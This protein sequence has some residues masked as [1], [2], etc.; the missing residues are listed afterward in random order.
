MIKKFKSKLI[1][2]F[3]SLVVIVVAIYVVGLFKNG[4]YET[5]TVSKSDLVITTNVSGKVVPGQEINLSFETPGKVSVINA[6][7]GDEVKEGDILARLNSAQ[8]DSEIE[9]ALANLESQEA[10]LQEISGNEELQ[11][12]LES[13]RK[14]LISVLKKSYVASDDVVRNNVD[15]FFEDPAS[16]SPEFSMALANYNLRKDI[17]S[18]RLE[19]EKM[20]ISWEKDVANLDSEDVSLSD[21]EKFVSNLKKIE[22]LLSIIS[23]G[24]SEF[25]DGGEKNQGQIDAYISNI[26]QS[27]T[28]IASLIVEINSATDAVRSVQAEVPVLTA[29]INSA[30]AVVGRLTAKSDDYV[31]R[32]PFD[33]VITDKDIELGV[34]VSVGEKVF[35]MISKQPLEIESFIPE[36]NIA[37]VD[38]GDKAVV[39]LDAFSEDFKL[40]AIVSHIDP[41]E[42]VK[43]GV[44]TY[45]ILLQ[46]D[47]FNQSVLSGMNT[48]IEIEKDRLDDQI[49]IPRYL[50][51]TKNGESFVTK[52]SFNK[53]EELKI[54]LGTRDSKGN[55][56]V[57]SGLSVG[58]KIVVPK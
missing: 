54:E 23:S 29:A 43:D 26:S 7:I 25:D 28:S 30:Q 15:S 18:K 48:E 50:I 11:S 8:I 3:V 24:G 4:N 52:L 41:R 55:V 22:M 42:T 37:G 47:E 17:E 9:E 35:S 58:E 51:T 33:G 39:T 38:L 12:K 16:S 34:V 40:G 6:K 14:S 57:S 56:V 49:V 5:F 20:F 2:F 45:R 46:F 32:A 36:V 53:K 21:A 19:I 31:I 44:T 10:K 1:A 13:S 27:R